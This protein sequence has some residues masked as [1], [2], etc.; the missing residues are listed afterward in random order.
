MSSRDII[1]ITLE[2]IRYDHTSFASH[3]RD[4]TPN[5]SRIATRGRC[6]SSCFSHDIWT[7]PSTASILT[8]L[9]SSAHRTWSNDAKLPENVKTIPEALREEG[10]QTVGISAIGQFSHHTG[11]DRGF[12]EFRYFTKSDLIQE[13]GIITTMKWILN[14]WQHSSGLTLDG[15]K[16]CKGYILNEMAKNHIDKSIKNDESLFLYLHHGDSHHAYVPPIVW[17]DKFEKELPMP[18]D[19]AISLALNMSENLHQHISLEKPFNDDEWKVLNVLYDTMVSYVDYLAG[20]LV[21]YAVKNLDNPMIVIT[22]DHGEFFDERNLLAHMLVTHT[23]VSHVPLVTQGLEPAPDDKLVQPADI[24]KILCDDIGVNHP[25]PVGQ[26][27]RNEEREFAVTQ[28]GGKRAKNKLDEISSFNNAFP[29]NN[30]TT[31]HLSTFRTDQWRYDYSS[32]HTQLY[33]RLGS[34]EE[35]PAQTPEITSEFNK[36]RKEW[37]E[38][39]GEPVG[40]PEIAEFSEDVENQ[41]DHL[42]YIQ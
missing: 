5:L 20:N 21:D 16:H 26:D 8:G 24:M 29:L 42:G 36:Y 3:P 6:F 19:E 38:N 15:R 1:W 17:R 32:T 39:V 31:D 37:F 14:L 22:S 40:K 25:V 12:D 2:S 30:F 9:P 11:L 35:V 33:K 10:Y 18:I 13:A 27:I 34:A 41:L 23:A 28:R 7:R 4:T